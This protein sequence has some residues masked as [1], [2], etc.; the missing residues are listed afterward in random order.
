MKKHLLFLLLLVLT[1]CPTK[2][3]DF[4]RSKEVKPPTTAGESSQWVRELSYSSAPLIGDASR[5]KTDT[6]K[7]YLVVRGGHGIAL[8]ETP[9]P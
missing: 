9:C 1:A 4:N 8:V 3:S 5:L 2:T 6:N 7:C